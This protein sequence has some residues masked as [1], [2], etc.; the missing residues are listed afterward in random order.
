M[1]LTE[2]NQKANTRKNPMVRKGRGPGTGKGKHCGKGIKGHSTRAGF[3]NKYYFEGGQ[4]P[5]V[6]RLPKKGFNNKIFS[7]NITV[8]NVRQLDV[9]DDGATVGPEEFLKQGL[10][11]RIQDG[12]KV[13][14]D[15]E[16]TKKLTVKAHKFSGSAKSKIEAAGGGVEVLT[17]EKSE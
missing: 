15:G 5:L 13:L 6:R 17:V 9:F 10:I 3:S 11:N 12:V 14:G 4:M 16:L 7:T 2:L 8:L 1:N